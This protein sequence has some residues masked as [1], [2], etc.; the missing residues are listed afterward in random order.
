M[1]YCVSS[2][3]VVM[4]I[5]HI[6]ALYVHCLYCCICFVHYKYAYGILLFHYIL[7]REAMLINDVFNI[8]T[9]Y[10][11]HITDVTKIEM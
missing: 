3:T 8:I 6:A 9:V 5:R 4:L 11:I 7:L 2:V 10:H 1:N